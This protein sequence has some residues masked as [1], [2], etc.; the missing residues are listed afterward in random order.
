M[1]N[2][3]TISHCQTIHT[4][5]YFDPGLNLQL[6]Q[7]IIKINSD[8]GLNKPEQNPHS[9]F[10]DN[11]NLVKIYN[12]K[13][14]SIDNLQTLEI[15]TEYC[16]YGNLIDCIK[17]LKRENS[18][19]NTIIL[20]YL[21]KLIKFFAFLQENHVAH[22]NIKPENIL[23]TTGYELKIGDLTN[24]TF[25]IDKENFTIILND[26][27][28]SPEQRRKLGD[29]N[30]Y[31][32]RTSDEFCPYK[33]D[34][35]SLGLIL[36]IMITCQDIN[37]GFYDLSVFENNIQYYVD[38]IQNEFIKNIIKSMLNFDKRIRPN[39]IEL[40]NI[41]DEKKFFLCMFCYVHD[42]GNHKT[43]NLCYKDYHLECFDSYICKSCN[44]ELKS[45]CKHC[46]K[47]N[48]E[49]ANSGKEICTKCLEEEKNKVFN[50]LYCIQPKSIHEKL[51][52][53]HDFCSECRNV[54]YK[55]L[56]CCPFSYN[57]E[58]LPNFRLFPHQISCSYCFN[59]IKLIQYNYY[60][61]ICKIYFCAGCKRLKHSGKCI[62]INSIYRV[63]CKKSR[64]VIEFSFDE[65]FFECQ[66]CV[67]HCIVCLRGLF[68]NHDQCYSL[69]EVDYI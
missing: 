30:K 29:R 18:S 33:S 61:N 40:K 68:I 1:N 52:C 3:N 9:L 7:K 38:T 45:Y 47:P 63:A 35:F 67:Y 62:S 48:C 60:C 55:C 17:H 54:N 16:V 36:L 22:R 23:I 20:Y 32:S 57:T 69:L 65:I 44:F 12:L 53:Q 24:A 64:S 4:K 49:V 26:Y 66:E 59:Q 31:I 14:G 21:K 6:F 13:R 42:R 10:K 34:V 51:D 41:L 46:N 56:V 39:F 50:C 5:I 11:P 2:I 19:F 58:Y 43:C 15:T 27:F 37:Q 28:K 8:A 25:D